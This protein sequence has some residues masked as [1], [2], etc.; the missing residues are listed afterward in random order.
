MLTLW[1]RLVTRAQRML[2]EDPQYY[3]VA[4]L[5]LAL[6]LGVN[7]GLFQSAGR[8]RVP[9]RPPA[10][11]DAMAIAASVASTNPSI[12]AARPIPLAVCSSSSTSDKAISAF[13]RRLAARHHH[14]RVR[15]IA[16]KH[17]RRHSARHVKVAWRTHRR[18]THRL[19]TSKWTTHHRARRRMKTQWA[20]KRA[21]SAP[22]E[23]SAIATWTETA[24]TAAEA[25]AGTM[26]S[27]AIAAVGPSESGLAATPAPEAAPQPAPPGSNPCPFLRR[28]NP[29]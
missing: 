7:A 4:L 11:A 6:G 22:A 8:L 5:T 29:K 23:P 18:S 10:A 20:I 17:Q 13:V 25:T 27:P 1:Q 14:N 9:P 26:M 28:P 16:H 12:L 15:L 2:A 19:V 24:A 21:P 3:V